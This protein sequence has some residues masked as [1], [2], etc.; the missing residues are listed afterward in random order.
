MGARNLLL[1]LL[2][3]LCGLA[4]GQA[5]TVDVV[6]TEE[7]GVYVEVRDALREELGGAAEINVVSAAALEGGYKSDAQIVVTVGLKAFQAAARLTGKAAVLGTL[8][9][10][11][12]YEAVRSGAPDAGARGI[13]AIYIDQ[14]P[15][16]Q[17]NLA[18]I[19]AP[20][21][22]K[23]GFLVSAESAGMLPGFR[24]AARDQ[25]RSE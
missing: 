13:S 23:I 10:R 25:K 1:L 12:A 19:V 3:A 17:L 6:L 11:T 15:A 9:P 18:R 16:R 2:A 7:S 14:P 21:R 20:G 22:Q 4:L 24:T 5:P 8:I